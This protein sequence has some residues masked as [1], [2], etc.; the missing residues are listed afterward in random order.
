MPDHS[1]FNGQVKQAAPLNT[2]GDRLSRLCA[3]Q[4]VAMTAVIAFGA[5]FATYLAVERAEERR[6]YDVLE[7][8]V[9]WRANELQAKIDD[10]WDMVV[11][12]AT[13]I[14]ANSTIDAGQLS[15][16]TSHAHD[17]EK[18]ISAINWAP[19]IQDDARAAFEAESGL[20]VFELDERGKP[21]PARSGYDHF[22]IRHQAVFDVSSPVVPGYDIASDPARRRVAELARDTGKPRTLLI[23]QSFTRNKPVYLGFWPIYMNGDVPGTV[24]A[25][26]EKLRGY[27]VAV[28]QVADVLTSALGKRAGLLETIDFYVGSDPGEGPTGRYVARY[29]AADQTLRPMAGDAPEAMAEY[30]F[31][32]EITVKDQRWRM[33]SSFDRSAVSTLRSNGPIA[34]LIAGILLTALLTGLAFLGSRYLAGLR[35]IADQRSEHLRETQVL[36]GEIVASSDDAMLTNDL[37][38]TITAWNPAAERIFGYSAG[39]IVGRSVAV[40]V[41]RAKLDAKQTILEQIRHDKRI[42]NY[43]TQRLHKDGSVIEVSMTISPIHDAEGR[44]IGASRIVRDITAARIADKALRESEGRYRST[45]DISPVGIIHVGPDGEFLI[46]NDF[47]CKLM[48]YERAELMSATIWDFTDP[49]DVPESRARFLEVMEGSQLKG[50]FPKR[51]IRKDGTAVWCEVHFARQQDEDG[52]FTHIISVIADISER[53][54]AE[55]RQAALTAQL[56]QSQ[57]MEAVGQLTGGIAHDFNNLL[58]VILANADALMADLDGDRKMLAELCAMAAQHGADLTSQLLAFSRRQV[59]SPS[60]LQINDL[61]ERVTDLLSRTLGEDIEIVTRLSE[62]LHPSVVDAIQLEAAILNISNNA[63]DAMPGGGRLIFETGNV[64]L[65]E[66]YAAANSEVTP[67]SYAMIALSDSGIGMSAETLAKAFDPFFTTKEVGKGTGLGLS[68]VYGFVRQ[69]GGHIKIYSEVGFGTTIKLYLPA[70]AGLE[71]VDTDLPVSSTMEG[72][73][74]TILLV[75]DDALVRRSVSRQIRELGYTVVEA[76]NGQ[77]ALDILKSEYSVDLLFTDFVMPGGMNGSQVATQAR[78]L[79]PDLKVLFTSGYT[80]MTVADLS[81]LGP[82]EKLLSKPYRIEELAGQLRGVMDGERV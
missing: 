25:R 1:I 67:G 30:R 26:R 47:F 64:I 37:D 60:S 61:V 21:F 44:V 28:W 24:S 20:A 69:S 53:K 36:L 62:D 41:D 49:S 45:F 56:Q 17:M 4:I 18:P 75:E 81:G 6:V 38:G 3:W 9:D 55:E 79:R 54:A 40:L 71:V 65:D 68:M 7:L 43:E 74:E 51:Y 52:N 77:D 50:A 59:L 23:A 13:H 39:E 34:T 32:R 27:V 8:R 72:G 12:T 66:A 46:A 22:P 31:V 58:T 29:S 42:Q 73:R 70:E 57:K 11:A 14:A 35:A 80:G 19:I 33:V 63:R 78:K 48:G 82:T 10:G 76:E 5:T 2:I 16:F 15:R